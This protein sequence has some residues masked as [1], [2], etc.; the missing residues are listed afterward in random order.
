MSEAQVFNAEWDDEGVFFY[1]AFN[2]DIADWALEHQKLG[3]PEFKPLRMTWIK[4]SF[5]WVLYRSHYGQ[6]HN[7]QRILK[8]K[9]SHDSL[10]KL[11]SRCVC[12]HGHGGTL[13][14]VQWDPE[15]DILSS[16]DGKEPRKMLRQRAIQIGLS[17]KLSEQY[18]ESILEIQDVTALANRVGAAHKRLATNPKSNDEIMQSIIPDLPVERPY[19][20]HA[21]EQVLVNLALVPG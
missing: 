6:K 9:I 21:S 8:I 5:A 7:Q 19:I 10:A 14:R 16:V 1:Q 3:G 12:G 13:G 20:P 11:L 4:P 17:K 15:R 18:V 2:D